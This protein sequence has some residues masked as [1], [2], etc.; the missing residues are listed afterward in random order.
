M[1]KIDLGLQTGT[2][3]GPHSASGCKTGS[4]QHE[5]IYIMRLKGAMTNNTQ[6]DETCT[7]HRLRS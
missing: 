6:T 7:S 2:V 3:I 4:Q 5:T 1:T